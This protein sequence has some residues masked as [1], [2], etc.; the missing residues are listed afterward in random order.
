[1]MRA[2]AVAATGIKRKMGEKNRA[3]RKRSPVVREV[4]PVRPPAATP[5]ELSIKLVTVLI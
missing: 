5:A 4:S 1:M 3:T 2:G